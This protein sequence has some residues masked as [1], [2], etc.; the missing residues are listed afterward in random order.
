TAPDPPM[1]RN[2]IRLAQLLMFVLAVLLGAF[3]VPRVY[4]LGAA[5][6]GTLY[7]N[8]LSIEAAQH[9]RDALRLLE[10]ADHDGHAPAALPDA[11]SEFS[12]WLDVENHNFTEPGEPA[13][14]GDIQARSTRLFSE[15]E[16]AAPGP[17]HDQ[18]FT[19][20]FRRLDDLT[21]LNEAAMFRADSRASRM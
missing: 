8:Y 4:E 13:L 19:A 18:E 17:R 10:L 16:S 11:R 20:L 12:R 2:R 6:R 14:A 21:R 1:L 7:R 9:M 5:I 3:T 15:I